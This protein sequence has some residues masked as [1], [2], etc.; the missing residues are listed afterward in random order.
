MLSIAIHALFDTVRCTLFDIVVCHCPGC[1]LDRCRLSIPL[2]VSSCTTPWNFSLFILSTLSK[3]VPRWSLLLS[4]LFIC[5]PTL[6]LWAAIFS[7][8]WNDRAVSFFSAALQNRV[9]WHPV[10][11]RMTFVLDIIRHTRKRVI[12][13]PPASLRRPKTDWLRARGSCLSVERSRLRRGVHCH[14]IG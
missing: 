1:G 13:S 10:L 12:V 7:Y 11:R 4:L 5:S 3:T 14:A 6:D 9:T 8:M 2:S